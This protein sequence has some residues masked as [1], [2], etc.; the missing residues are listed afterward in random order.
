M[1][2]LNSTARACAL[3]LMV[4]AGALEAET[5]VTRAAR[6]EGEVARVDSQAVVLRQGGWT[7]TVPAAD[8]LAVIDSGS[9]RWLA[10]EAAEDAA[11]RLAARGRDAE[12]LAA[13]RRALRATLAAV[14][15]GAVPAEV[16]SPEVAV[17][18]EGIDRHA[19]ASARSLEAI[20]AVDALLA[21]G[22][23]PR[24][25]E[26]ARLVRIA[27]LRRLGR[28]EEARAD[29]AS[30]GFVSTF[31][32][33]GPFDN[34][35]GTGFS[36]PGPVEAQPFDFNARFPGKGREVG[37]KLQPVASP[38]QGMI[39]LD[40]LFTP[41]DQ[42]LAY[43]LTALY[44]EQDTEVALRW[45]SDEASRLWVNGQPA[46]AADVRRPYRPDQNVVGVLL[47]QGWNHVLLKVGEQ[48]GDWRF[49][50]RVTALAGGPA[51]GVRQAAP[52]ELLEEHALAEEATWL[53]PPPTVFEQLAARPAESWR[54]AYH[55]GMLHLALEAHGRG[56][57]PDRDA[58]VRACALAPDNPAPRYA[59]SVALSAEAEFSVNR[60]DN[61]RRDALEE[62][63]RIDAS[64]QLARLDLARYYLGLGS[65]DRCRALV[66]EVL[67]QDPHHVFARVF[68][69][70]LLR[71]RG[72]TPL[73]LRAERALVQDLEAEV[74]SGLRRALPRGVVSLQL[75][76][77]EAR[78]DVTAGL[79]LRAGLVAQEP[80]S[81]GALLQLASA[82]WDA[83]R[84]EAAIA[85][86]AQA[87]EL[88]PFN[89]GIN[90]RLAR[91][92]SVLGDF[93]GATAAFAAGLAVAD[94]TPDYLYAYGRHL[95]RV[96]DGPGADALYARALE[97]NPNLV[98][99]RD[100]L[101]YRARNAPAV[102][103]YEAPWTLADPA[104][105]LASAGPLD[106]KRTHR[107]LFRLKVVKLNLDGTKSEF[108]Q[109]LLRVENR[110]GARQLERYT[111]P[112]STEQRLEFLRA[113]VTP[114][115]GPT[116][117]A[118]LRT[119]WGGGGGEFG[120]RRGGGVA[121]GPLEPGD[122]VEVRYR[123][124]DL[125]PGFFG[126]YYGEVVYFQD[127]V[128][129]DRARFVVIAP[130]ERELYFHTSGFEAA[131]VALEVQGSEQEG[132]QVHVYQAAGVPPAVE[133]PSQPWPK[134][135][136][137]Q[138]QVSTFRD[139]N[140][141]AR[142]YWGLVA[143][144]HESDPA[145]RA[146]V[147]E[148][149]AGATTEEEKIR[150][151]YNYV[152]SD[153]RY[154]ASWEFGIHGFKPYNATKIF[155]RKFG[156]CK[157]KSTLINTMLR[158]VGIR[159][160]PVLI[161]GEDMRG[162][163]DLTLPLMG[164]FNHCISYVETEHGGVFV[165][166]TAEHHSYGTLP[167]MDYGAEVVVVSPEGGRL[168]TIEQRPPS[169]NRVVESHRVQL[170]AGGGA[171]IKSTI[172]GKGTFD[173]VLRT[174]MGTPGRRKAVLEPRVGQ[175]WS[176]ARVVSVTA[177]DPGDLDHPLVLEVEVEVPRAVQKT[178]DG[179]DAL[180]EVKS[181]LFDMLYARG[182]RLS[183]LA[184]DGERKTDLVLPLPAGVEETVTYELP[185]GT[186]IKSL[187]ADLEL[188]TPFG[189]Y[190]RRY[191]KNPDGTLS[192]VRKLSVDKRR[193]TP[194]EYGEL[195]TFLGEVERA[196]ADR[197]VL[198]QG[199]DD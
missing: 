102:A 8:A 152:V 68:A 87:L 56:E 147:R 99:L 151:I 158:E 80:G 37:W 1:Q 114:A 14:E 4:C 190:T 2:T 98:A 50:L 162:R 82:E 169:E 149:C 150:R 153:I 113:R 7:V 13:Y 67:R 170:L 3:T 163:E 54:D 196:E 138:V 179:A 110:E 16:A 64:H 83:Q 168:K 181:W 187:P 133:E 22:L 139:W 106:P 197:P 51:T 12:A 91:W 177:S 33:V 77:A 63:L 69:S 130:A 53:A 119:Y 66:D 75:R 88:A 17:F 194:E 188:Q 74:Q 108:D 136:L 118:R 144:Q 32:L 182:Q 104:E 198:G 92:R 21:P 176:G 93:E 34:E 165:D 76:A 97:L 44:A 154:N 117:D 94:E 161:F 84:R 78:E 72:L 36:S 191:T 167:S 105:A 29:E 193:V 96:G 85:H 186:S 132:A 175:L 62:T 30:L 135:R 116:R 79:E 141:F 131:G 23:P 86:A 6:L 31:A 122:C 109:V 146:K 58:L 81:A 70:E 95:E 55:T 35:R 125:A 160:Y 127:S 156:D 107:V 60:E 100:Y 49:S 52:E 5:V 166:G 89:A 172:Q 174:L 19:Q 140:D 178:T 40:A 134:E 189:T 157:D 199:A 195:R 27:H 41:N 65:L 143:G 47:R 111:V 103:G 120:G 124:D 46:P 148:L 142:W 28:L 25:A 184:A 180:L 38:P 192:A 11:L 26:R 42:A 123:V 15:G 137:P 9:V 173:V 145:M 126:D 71:A 24:W 61:A 18:L 39:D 90:L 10:A 164:H 159:S 112:Y 73:A 171:K 155:A 57:H 129:L 48:T 128:A 43:A 115:D 121:L 101:E 185:Q 59:L 183:A 20:A 45:G